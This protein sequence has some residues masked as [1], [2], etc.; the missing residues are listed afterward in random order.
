VNVALVGALLFI[1][2]MTSLVLAMLAFVRELFIA[3]KALDLE[4]SSLS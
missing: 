2:S 3:L 1:A 4:I